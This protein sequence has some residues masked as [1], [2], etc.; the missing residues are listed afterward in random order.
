MQFVYI[1]SDNKDVGTITPFQVTKN[2]YQS[3]EQCQKDLKN[4]ARSPNFL[5]YKWRLQEVRKGLFIARDDGSKGEVKILSQLS[6]V[7]IENNLKT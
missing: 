2:E 1:S 4:I 6:C 3:L 7:K 5:G